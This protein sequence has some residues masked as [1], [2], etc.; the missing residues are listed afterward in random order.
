MLRDVINRELEL[1]LYNALMLYQTKATHTQRPQIFR[2]YLKFIVGALTVR[3]A[4]Q[5]IYS[6]GICAP[7][8]LY[9]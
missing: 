8:E 6:N 1:Y 5:T 9:I 2:A 3:F 7:I 4:E